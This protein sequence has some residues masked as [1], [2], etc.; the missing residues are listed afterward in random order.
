MNTSLRYLV[1]L[2]S[3]L[4]GTTIVSAQDDTA[5]SVRADSVLA[6]AHSIISNTPF[7]A[8]VTLDGQGMPHVR[9]MEPFTPDEDLTIWMAT[10]PQSRKV[11]HIRSNSTV[12]LHYLEAARPG[13]VT[14][15][16]QARLVDDPAEKKARWK[17]SWEPFYPDREKG[18]LLIEVTPQ[19][20]EVV[21]APDGILGDSLSWRPP[22]IQIPQQ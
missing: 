21:S 15:H 5:L 22:A 17:D 8:L 3:M 6:V 20:I 13:Y 16:G 4:L 2:A 1:V 14:I 9:T 12:V 7:C 10:N 19:R 18:Y 11:E